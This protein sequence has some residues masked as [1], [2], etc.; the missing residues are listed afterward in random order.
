V[1]E[2]REGL[3]LIWA[4]EAVEEKA[5]RGTE[6]EVAL[7]EVGVVMSPEDCHTMSRECGGAPHRTPP[8]VAPA[9][10]PSA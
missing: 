3:R 1:G 8:V 7:F 4:L 10:S 6:E 5:A 9:S 2:G